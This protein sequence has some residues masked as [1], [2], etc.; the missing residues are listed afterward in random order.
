MIMMM[1]R[2]RRRR[3]RIIIIITNVTHRGFLSVNYNLCCTFAI[4]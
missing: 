3:R 1:M 2:R 4:L